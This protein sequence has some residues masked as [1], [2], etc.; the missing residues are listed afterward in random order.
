MLELS[1]KIFAVFLASIMLFSTLSFTVQKHICMGEITDVSFFKEADS[2]NMMVE[3][4]ENSDL[5]NS[6]IYQENCCENVHELITGNDNE[7]QIVKSLEL[8]KAKFVVAF[9]LS[10]DDLLQSPD[11]ITYFKDSS[12]PFVVKHIYKLGETYLI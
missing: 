12:P 9:I 6:N 2:C 1:R 4:C 7:Q 11:R 5:S 8:Y 10:C 3:K